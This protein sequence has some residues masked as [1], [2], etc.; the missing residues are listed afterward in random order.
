MTEYLKKLPYWSHLTDTEKQS[1]QKAAVIKHYDAGSL[2]HGNCDGGGSCLGMVHVISGEIRAYILSKE[3]REITLFRLIKGDDCV[4]SASCV[5]SHISFDTQLS[6]TKDAD[7]LIIPSG[8]FGRLTEQN[9]FVR[10]FSYELATERFSSVMY[11]MQ[12]IIF[13]R[14]DQRLAEFLLSEY[15]R[16]G[17][18]EIHMSQKQIAESVNSAREVVARMLKQFAADGL[19]ENSRGVIVLKDTEGLKMLMA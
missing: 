8:V 19:I 7:I 15:E 18:P 1:V 4:L 5:I 3:G 11:V 6:V 16:T 9:I 14:F 10:C 2:L 17:V 12:Q 13:L